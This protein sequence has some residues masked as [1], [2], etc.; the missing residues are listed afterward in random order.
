MSLS[1][2]L[3]FL[4][5]M[6]SIY[7]FS[8]T[9]EK[10]T[11]RK[12]RGFTTQDIKWNSTGFTCQSPFTCLGKCYWTCETSSLKVFVAAKE[13]AKKISL[14]IGAEDYKLKYL[15]TLS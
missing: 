10:H 11:R 12:S 15:G 4:A 7:L 5:L 9:V 2:G 8:W 14:I 6:F 13:A 3:Y 1:G